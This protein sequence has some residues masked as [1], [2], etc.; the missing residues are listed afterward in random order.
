MRLVVGH[1]GQIQS[2]P[3]PAP[4]ILQ[5]GA[6]DHVAQRAISIFCQ[7]RL[8]IARRGGMKPADRVDVLRWRA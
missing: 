8:P 7:P 5:I 4:P 3:L 6:E 2:S 1:Q